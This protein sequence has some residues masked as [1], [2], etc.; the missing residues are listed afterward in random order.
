[1][2][3][4]WVN[5]SATGSLK[6]PQFNQPVGLLMLQPTA[7]SGMDIRKAMAMPSMFSMDCTYSDLLQVDDFASVHANE[8]SLGVEHEGA[9]STSPQSCLMYESEDALSSSKVPI[10]NSHIHN[11]NW[12]VFG[13]MDSVPGT[14]MDRLD[15]GFPG[16]MSLND[17]FNSFCDSG[18]DSLWGSQ[19]SDFFDIDVSS[20]LQNQDDI[21]HGPTL[22]EL[23]MEDSQPIVDSFL[24]PDLQKQMTN[25]PKVVKTQNQ[26]SDIQTEM[27]TETKPF[28]PQ[29]QMVKPSHLSCQKDI[30]AQEAV[31]IQTE[32][33]KSQLHQVKSEDHMVDNTSNM[34]KSPSVDDKTELRSLLKQN[35]SATK[36]DYSSLF[37][38]KSHKVSLKREQPATANE[39]S[40]DRKWEEIKEYL[41]DED[42]EENEQPA[43]KGQ[44]VVRSNNGHDYMSTVYKHSS[45]VYSPKEEMNDDDSSMDSN[46]EGFGSDHED[47]SADDSDMDDTEVTH[48][49]STLEHTLTQ[50]EQENGSQPASSVWFAQPSE[51]F[52]IGK[53]T[54]I[55]P[56]PHAGVSVRMGKSRR[57]DS[58][59]LTP[60]PR[61]L[62]HIGNELR[63][64]NKIISDLTPVSELPVNARQKSRK[65]K[66]KLASRA[67]RLKKKA[68]HEANKVKIHGLDDEYQR[69]RYVL[70]TIRQEIL[71]RAQYPNRHY[72]DTLTG[73]L[74]K[75]IKNDLGEM[76]GGHTPEF[77]N[78][79]LEKTAAGSSSGGLTIKVK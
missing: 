69:L 25:Q 79:V 18:K 38:S 2:N 60:N 26:Y 59:D 12:N 5:F 30:K 76:V 50:R 71:R 57:S 23:N 61:R 11:N 17:S 34:V 1:M 75:L 58:E 54:I 62:L 74:D 16:D 66:N 42:E 19:E 15:E 27:S 21:A 13:E 28:T 10:Q 31:S 63:K 48:G 45:E 55:F 9:Y 20:P 39:S 46:D 14:Y 52:K 44:S 3:N 6:C 4:T 65:E 49:S 68:Q 78:A 72:E 36:T 51:L 56:T 24:H 7:G 37:V 32:N 67:C 47:E 53:D 43:N 77:V 64:L 22:A 41:H 70:T 73:R 29:N 33:I 35:D 8:Q 40:M